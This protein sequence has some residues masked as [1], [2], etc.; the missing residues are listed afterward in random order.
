MGGKMAANSRMGELPLPSNRSIIES[1]T[2]KETGCTV[3]S[4]GSPGPIL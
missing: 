3:N 4:K 1:A 2:Q